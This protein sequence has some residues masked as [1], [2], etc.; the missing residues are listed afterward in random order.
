MCFSDTH[1]LHDQISNCPQADVLLH[2]GDFSN[3]GEI[4][5]IRSLVEWLKAYPAQH[6][7]VISGNHDVTMQPSYYEKNWSRFHTEPYDCN[8]AR[9][10]LISSGCCT[11]LEDEATEVDG[12]RIYGSPW[13][14]AFCDWAFNLERGAACK[15][16]WDKIP[17]EVDILI[18]HGPPLGMNDTT[19][20]A[21]RQGCEDLLKAI[22]SRDVPVSVSGHI[23]SGYGV[24]GD[25]VTLFANAS[26]CDSDYKPINPPIVFDLPPPAELQQGTRAVAASFPA[27][28]SA[29]SWD[30]KDVSDTAQRE[31]E[32]IL[33]KEKCVLLENTTS[34]Q[35]HVSSARVSGEAIAY[36]N[37]GKLLIIVDFQIKLAWQGVFHEMEVS[38]ELNVENLD[39]SDLNSFELRAKGV[40][41]NNKEASEE[42]AQSLQKNAGPAIKRAT[43]ELCERL[44]QKGGDLALSMLGLPS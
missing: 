44:S 25:G 4:E 30:E 22:Q 3:T 35:L 10:A 6:K 13:Q 29:A 16:A 8:E 28:R 39:S 43:N 31:L 26:T 15:S 19:S 27:P 2:A 41:P 24:I 11:Y 12:Y 33:S 18:T 36:N 38:G 34:T 32:R 21:G 23:H 20:R 17:S 7:V 14:P 42:A 9:Q 37:G 1:G 5:Q 40:G